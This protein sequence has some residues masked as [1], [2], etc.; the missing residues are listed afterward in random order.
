[1]LPLVLGLVLSLLL[2]QTWG[3]SVLANPTNPVRDTAAGSAPATPTTTT[4]TTTTPPNSPLKTN[5]S[6]GRLNIRGGWYP[7]VPYQYL[8]GNNEGRK[9]TGL[10]VQLL[11][12]AFEGELGRDLELTE[13]AWDQHQ[14]D[15][16]DG[17]RDVAAGAFRTRQRE[18]YAYYSKPYRYEEVVMY[19]RRFEPTGT[20][21]SR[22]PGA[23]KQELL[24]GNSK[25]GLVRGY[26]YGDLVAEFA[27]DP[28]Q[29]SRIV[30]VDDDEAN[31]K[32]LLTGEV[33]LAPVDLLVG[34][35]I[36][37]KNKWTTDLV[38]SDFNLFRGSIHV[39]FSKRT[40]D[41]EMVKK[42]DAGIEKMRKDG[43]YTRI[44]Q[45]YLFPVLLAQTI[46][47]DWFY[48]LEVLGTVAF[49]LSGILIAHRNDFSL[50][51]AFVL[52]ALPAVG[53]GLMR[54]LIVNR[55]TAAVLRSPISLLLVVALVLLAS[56][57]IKV[58]P[59]AGRL[60][61]N[62]N[63][64]TL[65]DVLDAIGLS[66]F[67]VVGVIVAVET[68]SNPLLLWGPILSALTVAGGSVLRDMV[69]GDSQHSSLRRALYAEIA[70]FWGFMLSLFIN[71]YS[72][73]TTHDPV[74]LQIAILI[75][76]LGALATRL[77]AMAAGWSAPRF[78]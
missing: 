30:W 76:L 12:E 61:K 28:R 54:D 35:T 21:A 9:L 56:A 33:T 40:T 38:A 71:Y 50:F 60:P 52:A 24:A 22:D 23:L 70:L 46:G 6:T 49:A 45:N 72:Q 43:R 16:R 78:P 18:Q 65:V 4:T 67:T 29:A 20:L 69:R 17:R 68:G 5:E 15:V 26:H 8:E 44:V 31:L 1:M 47:Q 32:N 11:R 7:W 74:R 59:K 37:W 39:L 57:L 2:T 34:A 25:V 42:F 63:I 51:G 64:G 55:D 10:D 73:A 62:F 36:A 48:A 27:A 77:V 53:G 13:V 19:R 3:H 75:T 41:P 58:L 14:R 66:A